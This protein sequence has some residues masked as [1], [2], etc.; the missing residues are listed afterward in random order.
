MVLF[1]WLAHVSIRTIGMFEQNNVG[2][3][4]K[5]SVASYVEGILSGQLGEACRDAATSSHLLEATNRI[6]DSI[7]GRVDDNDDDN[8][9]DDDDDDEDDALIV[10]FFT[11]LLIILQIMRCAAKMTSKMTTT[12]MMMMMIIRSH[13][14]SRWLTQIRSHHVPMPPSAILTCQGR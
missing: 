13:M 8:Y 9:D 5:N 6:L 3:Q 11:L 12:M 10:Q 4:L 7:D 1:S 2:V 14:T